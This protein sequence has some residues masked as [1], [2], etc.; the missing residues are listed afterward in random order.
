MYKSQ[1]E[2]D[3]KKAI[4]EL[5][6]EAADI[7][8][9]I[10]ENVLFGDY[11]TNVAL[12]LA[13]QKSKKSYQNPREIASDLVDTLGHPSYLERIDIAGPGFINFYLKDQ[14]LIKELSEKS[15]EQR[16]LD[17]DEL[18]ERVLVEYASPNAF[19]PLH[20]GHL[21]NIITGESISRILYYSGKEV[22]RVTYTSDIGPAVAKAIWGVNSMMDKF[23]QV[24]KE[25][26]LDEKARFLG[27][28]YVAGNAA[29]EINP[30]DKDEI[31]QI[32]VKIYQGDPELIKLWKKTRLWSEAYLAA[33]Y[34][35]LGTEFDYELWESDMG[36]RGME[37]VRAHLGSVFKES[38]GAIIFEGEKYG[39]HNRVFITQKQ[40][41]TYEAKELAVTMREQE[42]FPYDKA[43][44]VVGAEQSE[45]FK[46][47]T[48]AIELI[49]P[50]IT[51]KKKH[52]GYGFVSL[53]SGKMSSRLGNVI[54]ADDLIDQVKAKI[55]ETYPDNT[56]D[57]AVEQIATAA[58]KF[59]Y[60]KYG[61]SS[62][63][64]FDVEQSVALHGDSGPYLLYTYARINSILQKALAI[65][66]EAKTST[67]LEPE[68]REVL[69]QIDYFEAIAE[70]AAIELSPNDLA[71][72]L[73]NL[74]K[75]FN[76]FYEKHPVLGS[77][78]QDLR[79]KIA[80][81]VGERLKLGCYLLGF[82]VLDKM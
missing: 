27:N 68:E 3:L 39:L 36:D 61:L 72:Y 22:F 17:E 49:D 55:K 25:G 20:I 16:E 44:H 47:V 66:P 38:E 21:R 43:I 77:K 35:R 40:T 56:S 12:Q 57:K 1:I 78:K 64:S 76:Q 4:K 23:T 32:N 51:G 28:A 11:A 60:L 67:D 26:T 71:N 75:S 31:D 33:V 41:P 30:A 73:L 82:D 14:A 59:A 70:R 24:E 53:S 81:T 7:V 79:L 9:Y 34:V 74:A 45:Y 42:L 2:Q 69:R 54:V 37:V 19:K 65:K 6:F 8:V 46:V 13:K 58:I 80:T 10:S 29:Y 62:D 63:I 5:G 52:L 48:K 15:T 18:P 50:Q